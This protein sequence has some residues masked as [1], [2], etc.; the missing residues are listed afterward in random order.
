MGVRQK[1]EEQSRAQPSRAKKK[2]KQGEKKPAPPSILLHASSQIP[3]FPHQLLILMLLHLQSTL[4]L[5]ADRPHITLPLALALALASSSSVILVPSLLPLP[6]AVQKARRH[7]F[8]LSTADL[9][10]DD[11]RRTRRVRLRSIGVS[12]LK[13][14]Q[15]GRIRLLQRG[16][17]GCALHE[18]CKRAAFL[19]GHIL[20]RYRDGRRR[21]GSI[22]LREEL[23]KQLKAGRVLM[24][25]K[26]SDGPLRILS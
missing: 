26:M 14:G 1:H 25:I 6:H 5:D 15:H 9:L 3:R 20:H 8:R 23:T 17:R 7:H 16:R 13:D 18:I 10:R 12:R 19:A 11:G 24:A 2:E 21:K 4:S 22:A